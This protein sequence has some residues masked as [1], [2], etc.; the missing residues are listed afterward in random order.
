MTSHSTR[1]RLWIAV[2]IAAAAWVLVLIHRGEP[3]AWD[4]IEFY[5][6]T[7]W[8]AEGKLPFR[9]YWEHHMPLQWFLF[10]PVAGLF[11]GGPGV[12][13]VLVLRWAQVLLWIGIFAQTLHIARSEG[14]STWSRRAAL[15]MLLAAPTFASIAVQ[16]RVDVVGNLAFVVALA[17]IAIPPATRLRYVG[18]GMLLSAAVLANMRMAPLAIATGL[19]ALLWR[20]DERRWRLNPGALWMLIGLAA[21][22]GAFVAFLILTNS[23]QPF[24]N[25]VI[26]FNPAFDALVPEEAGTFFQRLAEPF[27]KLDLTA[28]V[29]IAAALTGIAITFRKRGPLQLTSLLAA[30][31]L[32]TI[33]LTAVHYTYHFQIVYILLIPA[34]AAGFELIAKKWRVMF[35]VIVLV[36]LIINASRLSFT[37]M[38]Y[39]DQIMREADARTRP[40]EAVFDGVGYALRRPS[41]YRYWFLPSAVR[42]MSKAGKI[43]SYDL[44]ELLAAP[45]AA[46]VYTLRAHYWFLE[47]PQLA[48]YVFRHYVPIYR[49]LWLPGLTAAVGPDDRRATWIV[50]RTGRYDIHA[51]AL[52][53]RHPWIIRP[54]DYGLMEG[55]DLEIPLHRLP[56]LPTETLQWR[57]DGARVNGRT[58]AL[59]Q[60]SRVELDYRGSEPAGV[61]V[62]P[63]GTATL[64]SAPEGTFVF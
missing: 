51:S 58:L 2:L 57:V 24:A 64:C 45:P 19:I 32:L 11:G 7:R 9:D 8:V 14:L 42:L 37:G 54:V 52:L 6:A 13:S 4:E 48:K 3:L 18:A 38:L 21:V 27:I 53:A 59:K 29:F 47:H 43:E 5:R 30:V 63:A 62:V 46:I 10:A 15:A 36:A 55:S 35:P 34:A 17:L 16:Y 28:V 39:Q 61:L 33:V 20:S 23:W 41:V 56:P 22:A 49:N 44:T 60:G 50:P 25:D 1:D 12:A 26:R 40:G 31:A